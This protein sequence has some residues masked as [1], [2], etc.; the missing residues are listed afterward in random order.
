[1]TH[2]EGSSLPYFTS[3]P[4]CR[5]QF[6]EADG[7]RFAN[8]FIFF[9]TTAPF[10]VKHGT[11]GMANEVIAEEAAMDASWARAR[12]AWHARRPDDAADAMVVTVPVGRDATEEHAMK[13][14]TSIAQ[15]GSARAVSLYDRVLSTHP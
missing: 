10:V 13:L 14:A 12:A 15:R 2:V 1:M 5:V 11:V 7:E 6:M 8:V 4:A 3:R 9:P